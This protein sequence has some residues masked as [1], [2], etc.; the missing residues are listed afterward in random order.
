MTHDLLSEEQ[1][2]FLA[3]RLDQLRQGDLINLGATSVV[4]Q[5]PSPTLKFADPQAMADADQPW[6]LT[7][8][9]DLGW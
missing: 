8:V 6:S 9:T 2:R 7:L 4:G 1:H 3:E 5:G